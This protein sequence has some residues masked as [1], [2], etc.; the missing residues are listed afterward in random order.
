VFDVSGPPVP[1]SLG[2]RGDNRGAL[3]IASALR[4]GQDVIARGALP[5]GAIRLEDHAA[6]II[7]TTSAAASQARETA[8]NERSL[9]EA[10]DFRA[11]AISG[12]NVDEEMSRLVQLQKSYTVAARLISITDEMFDELF[13]A[14]Q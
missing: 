2:G 13:R 6:R 10:F 9:T 1:A 14:A 5:A 3:G 4:A 12:V 7:A 8:A 11:A